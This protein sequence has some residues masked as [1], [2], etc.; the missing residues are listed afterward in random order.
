MWACMKERVCVFVC[1][2]PC[3]AFLCVFVTL[4]KNPLCNA[5]TSSWHIRYRVQRIY[6]VH[7]YRLVHTAEKSCFIIHKQI[8]LRHFPWH[9]MWMTSMMSKNDVKTTLVFFFSNDTNV[10]HDS[11]RVPVM[12]QVHWNTEIE[13][14]REAKTSCSGKLVSQRR[15][16]NILHAHHHKKLFDWLLDTL[17]M[18]GTNFCPLMTAEYVS[19]K[20]HGWY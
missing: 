1:V 4:W 12:L 2:W 15:K 20:W 9:T 7:M 11:L 19:K 16:N 13:W 3:W 10:F 17:G 6:S 5:E 8:Q 14:Q 18:F